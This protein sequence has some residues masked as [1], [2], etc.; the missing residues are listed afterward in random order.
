[1]LKTKR[2]LVDM[3]PTREEQPALQKAIYLASQLDASIELF[4]STHNSSVTSNWF[5][6]QEQLNAAKQAYLDK[7]RRW[8]KSYAA[9]VQALGIEVNIEAVWGQPLYEKIINRVNQSDV[10]LVIKSTHKHSTF[11]KLMFHPNDWQLVKECPVPLLLAKADDH[12]I[13]RHVMAAVDPSHSHDKPGELDV[14]ILDALQDL[15]TPLRAVTYAAHCCEPLHFELWQT[16]PLDPMSISTHIPDRGKYLKQLVDSH[17]VPFNDLLSP[18]DIEAAHRLLVE[19]ESKKVLP[20]LIEQHDIDLLVMGN[21]Y[22]SGLLGS[23]VE[24]VLDG[25]HCDVLVVKV[26]H[27]I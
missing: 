21:T 17:R 13:Y 14:A 18:Y 25:I 2:I 5:L 16:M 26:G 1:M 3:D 9:E 23:T 4:L 6:D 20:E 7:E 15:A 12:K 8:L 22:H 24:K 10:D 27:K 19:G 11:N